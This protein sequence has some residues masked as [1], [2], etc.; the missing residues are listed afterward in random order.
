MNHFHSFI[1]SPSLLHSF[2][3]SSSSP[4]LLLHSFIHSIHSSF[5]PI[6][7]FSPSL[8]L[9][10]FPPFS[11]FHSHSSHFLHSLLF[12]H[13]PHISSILSFSLTFLTF[14]HLSECLIEI[15]N[16]FQRKSSSIH[17]S[18]PSS[19]LRNNRKI[20]TPFFLDVP[21]RNKKG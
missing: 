14:T 18:T 21:Y 17:M 10:L 5:I 16:T 3:L 19:S 9:I 11:P 15:F 1:P 6:Y 8:F 12:T 7:S 13:I 20:N 2:I 4:S